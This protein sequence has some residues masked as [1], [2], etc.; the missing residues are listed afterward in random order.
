[1]QPFLPQELARFVAD[2]FKITQRIVNCSGQ[3]RS[4]TGKDTR[5]PRL[6]CQSPTTGLRLFE[7]RPHFL[8]IETPQWR[9]F[10]FAEQKN[11]WSGSNGGAGPSA[12]SGG[13][14]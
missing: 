12:H 8:E 14:A 4:Q 5:R 2:L 13:S 3:Q 11:F 1:M 6:I 7:E 10:G 9:T